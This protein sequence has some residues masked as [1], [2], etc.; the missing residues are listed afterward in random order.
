[1]AHVLSSFIESAGWFFEYAA[2]PV[3]KMASI[4]GEVETTLEGSSSSEERGS[5]ILRSNSESDR[6][7]NWSE[8]FTSS[9]SSASSS[10]R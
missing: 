9:C 8:R 4:K 7:E 6:S 5:E 10:R 1:M 3:D 2:P